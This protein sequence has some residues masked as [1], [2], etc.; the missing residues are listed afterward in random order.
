ML[1]IFCKMGCCEG[2]LHYEGTDNEVEN[3]I[4]LAISSLELNKISI[5][6]FEERFQRIIK[7]PIHEVQESKWYTEEHFRILLES[8]IIDMKEDNT[9]LRQQYDYVFKPEYDPKRYHLIF[10]LQIVSLISGRLEEKIAFFEKVSKAHFNPLTIKE[11]KVLI[12]QY[13]EINL[14][15]STSFYIDNQKLIS[16]PDAQSLLSKIYTEVNLQ[17]FSISF[18]KGINKIALKNNPFLK[19]KDSK[20]IDNEIIHSQ[21]F[22]EYFMENRILLDLLELRKHFYIKFSSISSCN[23]QSNLEKKH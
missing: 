16:N 1:I 9:C 12:I 23:D 14:V 11:M 3:N 6:E 19:E 10:F 15:K 8:V 7:I 20:E 18:I 22:T 5:T 4:R 13:L 2:K 17:N 21:E